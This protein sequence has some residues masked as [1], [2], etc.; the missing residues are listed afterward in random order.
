[1]IQYHTNILVRSITDREREDN[2]ALRKKYGRIRTS[3][4]QDRVSIRPLHSSTKTD[5]KHKEAGKIK[6]KERQTETNLQVEGKTE[7]QKGGLAQ[8]KMHR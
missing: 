4:Y 5:R 1:M 7:P 2:G 8:R 3:E 6:N